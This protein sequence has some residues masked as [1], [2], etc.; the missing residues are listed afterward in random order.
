MTNKLKTIVFYQVIII[1]ILS[2]ALLA[3]NTL[4]NKMTE[5]NVESNLQ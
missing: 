4:V 2:S 5:Y 1:L 3:K